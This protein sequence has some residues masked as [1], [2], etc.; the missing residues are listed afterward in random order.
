MCRWAFCDERTFGSETGQWCNA[1][2][3]Q[4]ST[5]S[6]K[7][8]SVPCPARLFFRAGRPTTIFTVNMEIAKVRRGWPRWEWIVGSLVI[9][10]LVSCSRLGHRLPRVVQDVAF[11]VVVATPILL[12]TMAWMGFANVQRGWKRTSL[13]N[14]DISL[15]MRCA[16]YSAG[17]PLDCPF[18]LHASFP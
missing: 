10:S 9:V 14:L 8:H 7:L 13:A 3:Q 18:F 16:V 5:L 17:N 1:M 11:L 2:L 4:L 12:T 6:P 15:W